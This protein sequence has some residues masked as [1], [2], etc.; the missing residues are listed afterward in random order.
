MENIKAILFDIGW[1]VIDETDFHYAW[2]V[3]FQGRLGELLGRAISKEEIEE[4]QNRAVESF[5]PSA[6][7]YM[8]WYF[9]KP[10]ENK[11]K[12]LRSEFDN[13]DYF[14]Y[15]KIRPEMLDVLAKLKEYYK[16]GIAANQ[17]KKTIK[18]LEE[19]GILQY[20]DSRLTSEEIGYSKPDIRMFQKVLEDIG[21]EPVEALM[22]GD[23]LDNDIIPAK[24]IGMK[25]V[26][27]KTGL[28][29][30]QQI[31]YPSEK[32]D[33]TIANINQILNLPFVPVAK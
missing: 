12:I 3:H 7:S 21:V 15:Y 20:F 5:A 17:P 13:F 22:V 25:T 10:D 18:Y 11:F 23:R 28:H 29:K 4:C 24:G 19:N 6:Y 33:Y 27:F 1:P 26:H 30:N 14:K 8:I 31:R 16:L 9:V 2:T 32:P